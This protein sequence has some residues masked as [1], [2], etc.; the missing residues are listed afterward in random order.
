MGFMVT[1]GLL[2]CSSEMTCSSVSSLHLK[3]LQQSA[4][5]LTAENSYAYF[6]D[7]EME[8]QSNTNA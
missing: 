8:R 5:V 3:F 7:E 1:R 6:I 4:W 2:L